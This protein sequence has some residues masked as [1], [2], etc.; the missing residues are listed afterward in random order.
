MINELTYLQ[1][2][3]KRSSL[4]YLQ[5]LENSILQS[6]DRHIIVEGLNIVT[7]E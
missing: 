6:C 7:E 2:Q 5:R 1:V 3:I 4:L